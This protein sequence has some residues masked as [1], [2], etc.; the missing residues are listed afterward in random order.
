MISPELARRTEAACA[1]VVAQIDFFHA[2]FGKV[3][4]D[5]KSDGTRV[6]PADIAISENIF[7][8]L[9]KQFPEDQYLSEELG[10][11]T[12]PIDVT[13]RFAWILDPIDGTNN[14]ALGIPHCA[15][16]LALIEDGMPIYGVIY[17]L[18][19]KSLMRGGPGFGAWDGAKACQVSSAPLTQESLIGF[20]SPFDKALVRRAQGVLSNFKIRGLGSATLHLA[21]VAAGLLD[22]SVDF[23]VKIWDL[24]AA[25]PLCRA[26]GGEVRFLNGEQL[27]VRRFDLK[28]DRIIYAAGSPAMCARLAALVG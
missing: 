14:Y 12:A 23:N 4:S 1:A 2:G 5:W 6:T 19:R 11:A 16:S 15:I 24:A 28:M 13:S 8:Q 18:G 10:D 3:A 27:P 9:G 7:R 25:I 21:Y 17:D 20:H 22:G 26:A